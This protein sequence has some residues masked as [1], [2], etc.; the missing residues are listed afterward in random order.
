MKQIYFY[1]NS[2]SGTIPSTIL[3]M[4]NVTDIRM[5]FC[6]LR[7][8]LP[9][10][11]MMTQLTQLLL[12]QNSLT[13]SIPSG[14]GSLTKLTVLYLYRN[15]L[16][17]TVPSTINNMVKVTQF[18]IENNIIQ[19]KTPK[20]VL[21]LHIIEECFV[22]SLPT[23]SSMTSLTYLSFNDNSIT[24]L[25]LLQFLKQS[26]TL[27]FTGTL[28]NPPPNVKQMFVGG[29]NVLDY[30]F[31]SSLCSLTSLTRLDVKSQTIC[32]PGC[33]TFTLTNAESL[34]DC[35]SEATTAEILC[36]F[37]NATGGPNWYDSTNWCDYSADISTW[38][39]VDVDYSGEVSGLLLSNNNLN[40]TLPSSIAELGL[41]TRFY[42]DQNWL[43]GRS[44]LVDCLVFFHNLFINRRHHSNSNWQLD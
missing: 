20:L 15:S 27:Q 3:T 26:L 32:D 6:K 8:S 31:L 14:F 40:G 43:Y 23:M 19:G 34:V 13:K 30:Y 28:P 41:M 16:T 5:Y 33:F 38:Y 12:Y 24:G 7:G 9:N 18:R 22:G 17:G 21:L 35:P 11:G 1:S 44:L 39:G 42:V 10:F 2:I 37:Y 36:A 29:T 25:I 4:T